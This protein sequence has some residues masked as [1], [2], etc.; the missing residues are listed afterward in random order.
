MPSDADPPR[1][2]ARP[3]ADETGGAEAESMSVA[4]TNAQRAALGLAPLRRGPAREIRDG[5]K[6]REEKRRVAETADLKAKVEA[7]KR[8]REVDALNASTAKLGD[9]DDARGDDAR[10]WLAKSRGSMAN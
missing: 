6:E 3:D 8:Q 5:A 10:A 4:D 9:E 2:R 7:R 1:A